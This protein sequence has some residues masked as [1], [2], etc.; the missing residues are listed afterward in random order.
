MER[1]RIALL[2]LYLPFRV[3][4][5][6]LRHLSIQYCQRLIDLIL[7]VILNARIDTTVILKIQ[8]ILWSSNVSLH[9]LFYFS[10]FFPNSL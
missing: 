5:H 9:F 6:H 4:F 2:Q 3:I 8:K 1:H 10:Q 7:T